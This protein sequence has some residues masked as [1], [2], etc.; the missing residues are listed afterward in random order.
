[1]KRT[2]TIGFIGCGQMGSALIQG[3]FN[4]YDAQTLIFGYDPSGNAIDNV[5]WC[6]SNSEVLRNSSIVFLCVKPQVMDSVLAEIK[7]SVDVDRHVIVSIAAGISIDRIQSG[8][9]KSGVKIIRVMPNTPCLVQA[10]ASVYAKSSAVLPQDAD[11]VHKLLSSVGICFEL[12]EELLDAVTGLS[13]SGPAFVFMM[14]EALADGGVFSGLPRNI[15]QE[16]AV[17]TAFGSAKLMLETKKHP[18]QLKD[19]VAS[20]GGTTIQGI[21][22]LEEHGVRGAFIS[23]VKAATDRSKQLGQK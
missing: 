4:N 14:I 23:A 12:K 1:M 18:G 19:M 8:I 17:Q 15:A 11:I 9:Q 20:P 16:L 13:G 6:H 3:I 21:S 22:V 7:D 2:D 10:G 5:K